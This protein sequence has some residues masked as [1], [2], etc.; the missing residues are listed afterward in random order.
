MKTF[1]TALVLMALAQ[2][3]PSPAPPMPTSQQNPALPSR[4]Q[5]RS[6]GAVSLT[7]RLP[8]AVGLRVTGAPSMR[9][10]ACATILVVPTPELTP[11]NLAQITEDMTVMCRILDKT[12]APTQP[13]RYPVSVN[14]V[15]PLFGTEASGSQGLYLAGYG[16]LFFLEAGFPLRPPPQAAEQTQSQ[17]EE[18]ATDPLWSQT[19][20]E[21]QGVSAQS[22][23]PA[24]ALQPYDAQKVENL[25]AALVKSLR[26]AANLRLTSTQDFITLVVVPRDNSLTVS[27]D[28]P[29]ATWYAGTSTNGVE[30][31][32]KQAA[33]GGTRAEGASML[34]LR[35]RKAQADAFAKGQLTPDQFTEKVQ[36]LWSPANPGPAEPPAPTRS[37]PRVETRVERR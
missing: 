13:P 34:I 27:C 6:T 31:R 37:S 30:W 21:L 36:V 33:G 15:R 28:A 18:P 22:S 5:T 10:L 12:V 1:L 4:P 19:V 35:V 3:V 17:E 32:Y 23:G 20:E 2:P 25:K 14:G 9:E 16:A 7:P 29:G 8:A 26:H 24:A 11:E